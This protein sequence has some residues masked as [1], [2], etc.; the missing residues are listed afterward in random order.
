MIL[1]IS[2]NKYTA[3]NTNMWILALVCFTQTFHWDY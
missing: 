1:E 2:Y 3:K